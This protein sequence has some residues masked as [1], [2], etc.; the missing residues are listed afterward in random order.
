M[1]NLKSDIT[2]YYIINP[3]FSQF[4]NKTTRAGVIVVLILGEKG[5]EATTQVGFCYLWIQQLSSM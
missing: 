3:L 5:K 2:A 4:S 1:L